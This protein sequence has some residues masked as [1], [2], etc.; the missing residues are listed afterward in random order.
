MKRNGKIKKATFTIKDI[1]TIRKGMIAGEK[2]NE[3]HALYEIVE[4]AEDGISKD[5]EKGI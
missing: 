3:A 1:S 2:Y 4:R 5:L